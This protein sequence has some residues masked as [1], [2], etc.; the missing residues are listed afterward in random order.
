MKYDKEEEYLQ[1]T[2]RE[3]DGTGV[4][5]LQLSMKAKIYHEQR[6]LYG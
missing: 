6:Y 2:S 3:K 5:K 4:E 1:I